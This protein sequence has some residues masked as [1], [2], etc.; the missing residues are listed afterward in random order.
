MKTCKTC[1][2]L[3]KTHCTNNKMVTA[4]VL[5]KPPS[6]DFSCSLHEKNPK[7]YSTLTAYDF[8]FKNKRMVRK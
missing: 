3:E 8:V 5:F 6:V 7:K 2:Y 4:S 1:G